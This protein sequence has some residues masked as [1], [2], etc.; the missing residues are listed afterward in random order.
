MHLFVGWKNNACSNVIKTCTVNLLYLRRV[1]V[2][3]DEAGSGSDAEVEGNDSVP[4]TETL[5]TR[6]G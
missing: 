3:S 6:G 2:A 4:V 1:M 5:N